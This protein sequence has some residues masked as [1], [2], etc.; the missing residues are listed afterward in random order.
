M[1]RRPG[2]RP[3]RQG[4]REPWVSFLK[5]LD[6]RLDGAVELH[7]IGGFVITMH[8][9]LSRATSDID[10]LAAVPHEQLAALQRLGGQGS[11]LHRRFKVY[12]QPV[13]VA[14]YPEDYESRLIRMW[15]GLTLKHLRLYALEAH[16]L[17]L[18]KLERNSDVDRRDICD[19]AA[20]GLINPTTLRERYKTEFRPN[21][22]SNVERH[23]LTLKLWT[24]MCWPDS[25][26]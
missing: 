16:D 6:G 20:A 9:G 1:R 21:L 7:C 24:E 26:I 8:F 5:A 22:V 14:S 12:L 23:D 11:E 3:N 15:P 19:L 17:A 25:A 13:T 10:I 2:E 18:T 4:P